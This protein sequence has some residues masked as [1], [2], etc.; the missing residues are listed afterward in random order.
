MC[1]IAGALRLSPAPEPGRGEVL[2]ITRALAHRGPHGEGLWDGPG[3]TLGHRRL[4]IV[5]LTD[6]GAQP[7]TCGPLTLVYNGELYNHR[8]LRGQLGDH[9]FSSGS[10]TEVV[11]AAWLRWGPAALHR[12]DGMY[13]FAL[14]D[15]RTRRLHLVRD[16]LGIKPLY[17]HRSPRF[18]LFASEV[19]ALLHSPRVPREPDLPAWYRHLLCSSTLQVDRQA[20]LLAGIRAVP[21]ATCL[22]LDADGRMST[23]RY[24]T[25]P[26]RDPAEVAGPA[27]PAG[28][29]AEE[30][31]DLFGQTVTS[32]RMG[33]VPVAAFLSGGLDSSAITA[34]A[35]ASGP[36]TALTTVHANPPQQPDA[37]VGESGD[38]R[39]S[40]ILTAAHPD[41]IDHQVSV[42]PPGIT[43]ADL[44]AVCDPA[45][46][47]EDPRH[48][49]ILGNYRAA[50]DLGLRVVLNG[51]GA[52]ETMAG[53]VGLPTFVD[54]VL[55]VRRPSP[56]TISGL[57]ASRQ[58]A[59]L[60]PDVLA[61]RNGAHA[62]VLAFHHGLPGTPLEAAGRLLTALQ[63]ARVV[64]FEDH[65]AMH[66]GVEARFPFLAHRLVE[67]CFTGP[68]DQHVRPHTRTGKAVLRD[69]VADRL[70][71]VLLRRPK[72]VF[73][74]PNP[75]RLH[76]ALAAL[77]RQHA[78]ALAADPLVA[79]LFR[80]PPADHLAQLPSA[81]QWLL[82]M[83]WRWHTTVQT[84]TTG[85]PGPTTPDQPTPPAAGRT[86]R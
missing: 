64:Q 22:T 46:I 11:L 49:G 26:N 37:D 75:A 32:M 70:P 10:D 50:A 72:Q 59:H 12:F 21:A 19:A 39:H 30:L 57:P 20:T 58:A 8:Q 44:D 15:Q 42:Q 51:Q 73:P 17:Y 29:A 65:L 84:T 55:D 6:R 63:L 16:R 3:V 62:E 7:M 83:T 53:Y 33:D 61:A 2:A 13:A 71:A 40:R 56:A 1:G 4:A 18:L 43:L 77:T 31:A 60:S 25:L 27:R 68:Y 80:L 76:T 79:H 85:R 23:T 82:L 45:T 14:Y 52:D 47:T 81:T 54:H 36:I 86:S 74:H 69:A 28:A 66:A 35:A 5:D 34:T 48:L 38:L 24:W 78:A 9:R 67:W 41:R